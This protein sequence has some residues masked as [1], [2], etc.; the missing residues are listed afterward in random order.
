MQLD[1]SFP[2]REAAQT[3]PAEVPCDFEA[4]DPSGHEAA[5]RRAS[6]AETVITQGKGVQRSDT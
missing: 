3:V 2:E 4:C 6:E 1:K 5:A